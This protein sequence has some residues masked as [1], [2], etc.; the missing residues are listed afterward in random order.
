[1]NEDGSHT[2]GLGRRNHA[3]H[4]IAE[5]IAAEPFAL[6]SAIDSKPAEQNDGNRVRHITPDSA[7]RICVQDRTGR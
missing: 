7:D 5:E 6:P 4:G 2:D 3:P 1:M